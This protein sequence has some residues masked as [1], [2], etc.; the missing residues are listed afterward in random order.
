VDAVGEHQRLAD[1]AAAVA[2][3]LDLGVEPQVRVAALQ[4]PVAER[5]DL[6]VEALAD[7]RDLALRDPQPKRFDHL[8]D[9]ARRDAGDV[10]LLD[11]RDK[12]LLGALARLE[13]TRE[14]TAA[15]DL[16]D[17]QLELARARRPGARPVAVA[18][19]QPL[20]V[21]LAALG[22]NQLRHLRLHQLLHNPRK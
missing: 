20:R 8:V 13:E 3:A 10:R 12:R 14:V 19:R 1:N 11:D 6:L 5:V 9:L 17:R 22:A 21:A 4:R 2:D 18:M 7:S 15:A 16:R